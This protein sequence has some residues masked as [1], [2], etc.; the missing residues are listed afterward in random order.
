MPSLETRTHFIK[1]LKENEI[2]AVFHYLPL[3]KS[4]MGYKLGGEQSYCPVTENVSDRLVRLPF[5]NEMS[6]EEL[7]TIVT[8]IVNK[9]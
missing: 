2:V 7:T 9:N 5:F 3:H 1:Y 4:D 6:E 8:K